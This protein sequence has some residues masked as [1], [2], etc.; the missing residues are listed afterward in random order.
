MW[1]AGQ[2][3]S[4]IIEIANGLKEWT[5]IPVKSE[6]KFEILVLGTMTIASGT[7]G[8]QRSAGQRESNTAA[9]CRGSV[10]FDDATHMHFDIRELTA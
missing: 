3:W 7:N 8:G 2:S 4:A 6:K 5:W 10:H 1:F 9:G